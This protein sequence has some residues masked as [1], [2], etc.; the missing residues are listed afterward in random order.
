MRQKLPRAGDILFIENMW[1][2]WGCI[3]Q[4]LFYSL[5]NG[6]LWLLLNHPNYAKFGLFSKCKINFKNVCALDVLVLC[7][8]LPVVCHSFPSM[9]AGSLTG[10]HS[11]NCV[12]SA[13]G[14]M[15]QPGALQGSPGKALFLPHPPHPIH[16]LPAE[17]FSEPHWR[18]AVWRLCLRTTFERPV[19]CS[20]HT[21]IMMMMTVTMTEVATFTCVRRYSKNFTAINISFSPY[22]HTLRGTVIIILSKLWLGARK[23][24]WLEQGHPANE[25]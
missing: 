14:W 1:L 9:S 7:T 13:L 12:F 24:K 6:D 25:G 20:A 5:L 23:I 3:F 19:S 22:N 15:E 21:A 10:R 8:E 2:A 4:L 18:P 16:S 17:S 11:E